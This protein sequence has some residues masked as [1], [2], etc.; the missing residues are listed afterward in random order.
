GVRRERPAGRTVV[1]EMRACR[2]AGC[3]SA[4]E[5]RSMGNDASAGS[6]LRTSL[7]ARTP[8]VAPRAG[9]EVLTMLITVKAYPVIGRKTGEAVCVAGVSLDSEQAE[10]IRL[11][12][13]P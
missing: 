10:W 7:L 3:R 12:P 9:E 4:G 1:A 11:F 2:P 8:Q 5:D 6:D 13:V